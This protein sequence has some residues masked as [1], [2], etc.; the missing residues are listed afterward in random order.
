[1]TVPIASRVKPRVLCLFDV[2]GTL[3][4][5]RKVRWLVVV[6][7]VTIV[8]VVVVTVV[9]VTVVYHPGLGDSFFDVGSLQ[10]VVARWHVCSCRAL[11]Y[12]SLLTYC[13]VAPVSVGHYPGHAGHARLA[14]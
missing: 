12:V 10:S 4:P 3:T 9:V 8:V 7:I 14:A 5:P 11:W 6:Y 13:C 2:D 1:M